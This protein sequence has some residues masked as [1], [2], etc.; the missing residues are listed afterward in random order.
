MLENHINKES[1]INLD[2]GLFVVRRRWYCVETDG[3]LITYLHLP[4]ELPGIE[5]LV[6]WF[7]VRLSDRF[8]QDW[9]GRSHANA[10]IRRKMR[11][12][13]CHDAENMFA[14]LGESRMD[15]K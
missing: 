13:A 10:S 2:I 9:S 11:K 14:E 1:S 5:E 6:V 8:E 4:S 3:L 15:R 7:D 12:T